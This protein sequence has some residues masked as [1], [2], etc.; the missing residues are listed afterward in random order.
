MNE[1]SDGINHFTN[2]EANLLSEILCNELQTN[3]EQFKNLLMLGAIYVNNERQ[4]KDK[5]IAEGSAFRVHSKP[6][7]YNCDFPWK[8]LIVFENDFYLVL[9]K[10]SGVPSH[11]AVDNILDNALTQTSQARNFPL[12]ITHRLDTLT[13]GLIVYAKKPSFAKSFNVQMQHRKVRKKYVALVE[14]NKSVTGKLTN[15]MDPSP[16]SPKRLSDKPVEGYS[17]CELEI[18]EQKLVSPV[19]TWVHINL[20]TGRTH[21][22]RAQLSHLGAPILGDS[23][24]GSKTDFQKNAIALRS[25]EIEFS[26]NDQRVK[27]KISTDFS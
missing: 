12:F 2:L 25:C 24:Y 8:D 20:L 6:R 13:S 22:I 3:T 16:G 27:Y 14:G 26:F 1:S 17:L 21:Q 15:Y 7:R 11:A 23:L 5:L 10:P 19:V 4:D 9:N 18:L